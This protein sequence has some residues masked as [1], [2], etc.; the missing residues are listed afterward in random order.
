[1]VAGGYIINEFGF[2]EVN[3]GFDIVRTDVNIIGTASGFAVILQ[4][5]IVGLLM[6]AFSKLGESVNRIESKMI[7]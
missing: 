2:T 4:G 6:M 3:H 7:Q 5:F 1:M